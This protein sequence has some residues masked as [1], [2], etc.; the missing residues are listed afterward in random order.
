MKGKPAA[1]L[2]IAGVGALSFFAGEEAIAMDVYLEQFKWKNR[3]LLVFAPDSSHRLFESLQRE[4]STQKQAVDDRDLVVFEIL[5]VGTSKRDG[6]QLD[7][8]T[9]AC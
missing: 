3:L 5:G 4:I 8:R 1:L 2:I 6:T 9:A 7:P